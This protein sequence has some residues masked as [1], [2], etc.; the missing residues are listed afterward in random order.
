MILKNRNSQFPYRKKLEVQEIILDDNGNIEELIV[1]EYKKEGIVHE[2][3]TQLT[4][5]NLELILK[6]YYV[7]NLYAEW[8]QS[9]EEKSRNFLIETAVPLDVIITNES[10]N[11][12]VIQK[13]E[14]DEHHILI[15]VKDTPQSRALTGT[16]E[17]NFNFNVKL[18]SKDKILVNNQI[19]ENIKNVIADLDG[20]I[21]YLFSSQAPLD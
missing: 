9:A 3:G 20:T 11:Y 10:E 21:L 4:A 13:L 8:I 6:K 19:Q 18:V 16:S 14:H 12:I 2:E 7:A 17:V 5:K 1:D 15:N